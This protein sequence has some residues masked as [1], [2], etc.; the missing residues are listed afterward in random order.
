MQI[1][2]H[3]GKESATI[4]RYKGHANRRDR[5]TNACQYERFAR[6]ERIEIQRFIT[7]SDH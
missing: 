4:D 1:F 7:I 2:G 5:L 6:T 3:V